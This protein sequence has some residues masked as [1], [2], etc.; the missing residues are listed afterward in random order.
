VALV[1][2]DTNERVL[3]EYVLNPRMITAAA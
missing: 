3:K 2:V 1:E